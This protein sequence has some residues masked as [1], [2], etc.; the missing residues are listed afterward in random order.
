M[1]KFIRIQ[2]LSFLLVLFVLS[3]SCRAS[4]SDKLEAVTLKELNVSSQFSN[5]D[6]EVIKKITHIEIDS[7]FKQILTTYIAVKINS[8]SALQ[9]YSQLIISYDSYYEDVELVFA[10][11]VDLDGNRVALDKNSI[12]IQTPPSRYF[13]KDRRNLVF[14]MPSVQSGS[15]IEY[16]YKRVDKKVRIPGQ[17]NTTLFFY[18][19][20]A[21]QDVR[22][23]RYDPVRYSEY[24]V[25]YPQNMAIKYR[26]HND[27]NSF[28]SKLTKKGSRKTHI[29]TTKNLPGLAIQPGMPHFEMFVPY[30][31][32]STITDWESIRT[33][34]SELFQSQ[35]KESTEVIK[36][37][38]RIMSQHDSDKDRLRAVYK[39]LNDNIRY[40]YSHVGRGGYTPHTPQEVID[41]GFGD[42]KD[43][44]ML[45]VV[46]LN[47]MGI[48]AKPALI[49]TNRSKSFEPEKYQPSFDHM[50][51]YLPNK[52]ANTNW[53]DSTANKALFPGALSFA[54]DRHALILTD[55]NLLFEIT[56]NTTP[57]ENALN[58][59][60]FFDGFDG[61]KL[62]AKFN[63][64]FSGVFEEKYRDIWNRETLERKRAFIQGIIQSFY[65]NAKLN[66]YEGFN[67]DNIFAPF[68]ISGNFLIDRAWPGEP[69]PFVFGLS[70]PNSWRQLSMNGGY[71]RAEDRKVP[72]LLPIDY[73][74]NVTLSSNS[75]SEKYFLNTLSS[76]ANFN[77]QYFDIKQSLSTESKPSIITILANFYQARVK[78]SEYSSFL[79]TYEAFLTSPN[80][81]IRYQQDK[82]KFEKEALELDSK[83]SII[84]TNSLIQL[85]LD[86]GKFDEA[87]AL[88]SKAVGRQDVI[89]ETYYLLGLSQAYTGDTVSSDE[90]LKKAEELGYE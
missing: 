52:I 68:H 45:A 6:A 17:F 79:G 59:D 22:G 7:E 77:N 20:H 72:L 65:Q 23:Y 62:L 49:D 75:P 83:S 89:G 64:S 12:Q 80:W 78:L 33:W 26:V 61:E 86:G 82:N 31:S 5:D 46:L 27:N 70:F 47:E 88:A 25:S 76:G 81:L 39:Y 55:P 34:A 4:A 85:F 11:T 54:D 29:L 14:S 40:I 58:L 30:V 36:I 2:T 8:S 9:D 53:M 38:N 73:S 63:L 43:Q 21:V 42:C 32:F 15:V 35:A 44:T 19:W 66:D 67:K 28:K 87:L 18:F 51:V 57:I 48:E 74:V 90:S 41:N 3:Q 71:L 24:R 84:S 56:P 60:I 1:N 50:L 37:A 13:Y 16:Q 69:D 10:N